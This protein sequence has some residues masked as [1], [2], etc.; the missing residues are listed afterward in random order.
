MKDL[1]PSLKQ[2]FEYICKVHKP[3]EYTDSGGLTELDVVKAYYILS[4]Y[5]YREGEQLHFGIKSFNLLASA[6]ARQEVAFGGCKKWAN[7]FEI[8]ATLLYGLVKNH[9]FEDGNKRTALLSLLLSLNNRGYKVCRPISDLENLIVRIAA[10]DLQQYGDYK[11]KEAA[12]CE[13]DY[14][15]RFIAARIK[16]S[17]KKKS[18]QIGQLKYREFDNRLREFGV[19]LDSQKKGSIKVYKKVQVE[20]KQSRFRALFSDKKVQE[21]KICLCTIPFRGWTKPVALGTIKEVLTK[22]GLT[23][24][25]GIDS[26]VFFHHDQP[27]YDLIKEYRD[28]LVRLKDK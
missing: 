23:E 15:I 26:G 25:Q 19:Y 17:A 24:E 21:G 4:D 8:M 14:K 6:V 10:N 27:E 20:K 2:S 13:D 5:F 11:M 1:L 22:A 3:R 16:R 9:A 7:E 18:S 12:E 28:P